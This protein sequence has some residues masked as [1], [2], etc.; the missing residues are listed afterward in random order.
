MASARAVP[1]GAL[2]SLLLVAHIASAVVGFGALV[3]TGFQARRLNSG[4]EAKVAAATRYFRPGV[5]WPA[6]TV[7]LVPIL[8]FA[9]LADSAGAFHP[10]DSFV[11]IGLV[12]WAAT[13]SLAEGVL[14]PAERRIQQFLS[15]DEVDRP[16]TS[17]LDTDCR[18]AALC[19][20][21]TALMFVV[22]TG[23]MISKP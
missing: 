12:L 22:A 21:S 10:S 19:A 13:V 1:T 5:N 15:S 4:E 2:Y 14:W 7:Y 18:R 16:R 8:G 17:E 11:L 9:L 23:V 20:W 3:I 6:R